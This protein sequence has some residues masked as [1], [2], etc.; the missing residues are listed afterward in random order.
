M[1][2]GGSSSCGRSLSE[3]AALKDK[4][5]EIK[6]AF[7]KFADIKIVEILLVISKH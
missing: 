3:C 1:K 2:N 4:M 7:A 6:K 5:V